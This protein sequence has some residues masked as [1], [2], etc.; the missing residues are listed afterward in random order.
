MYYEDL[1]R[2]CDSKKHLQ[3]ANGL[4]DALGN[5]NVRGIDWTMAGEFDGL[6]VTSF[7]VWYGHARPFGV[8]VDFQESGV[9]A[10][11]D[12]GTP[13]KYR[14]PVELADSIKAIY[15]RQVIKNA[16]K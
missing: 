14:H 2:S 9:V 8:E 12:H 6:E 3:F 11:I 13:K 1:F 10:T 15:G 5:D 7:T 16:D 4:F